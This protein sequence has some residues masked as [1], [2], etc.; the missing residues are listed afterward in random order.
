MPELRAP[1]LWEEAE[2]TQVR[3]LAQLL[4][5]YYWVKKLTLV[6]FGFALSALLAGYLILTSLSE[7]LEES[8]PEFDFEE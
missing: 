4:V 5:Y 6:V 3:T 1:G 2:E 8:G 7:L